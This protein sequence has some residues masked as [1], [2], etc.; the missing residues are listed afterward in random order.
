MKRNSKTNSNGNNIDNNKGFNGKNN[1]NSDN[2]K[3]SNNDNSNNNSY[4]LRT[5]KLKKT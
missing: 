4:D 2:G 3:I 5:E 1:D